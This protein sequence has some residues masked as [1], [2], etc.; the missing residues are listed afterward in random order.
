MVL[1]NTKAER[2][3]MGSARHSPPAELSVDATAGPTTT[4]QQD[5]GS[6]FSAQRALPCTY[7]E[8]HPR[9]GGDRAH[10]LQ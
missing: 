2:Q 7:A 8:I 3:I 10:S 4:P 6:Q 5:R 9:E 1:S